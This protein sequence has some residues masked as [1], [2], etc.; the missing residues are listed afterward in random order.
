MWELNHKESWALKNWCFW[1]VVLEKTLESP[2]DCK[3]SKPVNP[4]GNQSWI[5][6][7][8]TDA[9]ADVP[10]LWPHDVM[11]WLIR[12]D[13]D[14]GKD[15]RQ[16]EK[17]TEGKMVGWHH[18]LNGP[19]FEQ[20]LG[21]GEGQGG[22]ACCS[23]WGRR[24]WDTTERLNNCIALGTLSMVGGSLEGNGWGRMDPYICITESLHC[25]PETI[26]S[27]IGYTPIQ[28]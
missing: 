9:E 28:K 5:L 16:E 15:W 10:I 13:P 12:K 8:R 20:A 1:T 22:L 2:L 21:D 26:T 3:E 24:E 18:Q 14:A 11:S 19:E 23:P 6:T 27:L 7:G 17:M 4:K 25:L